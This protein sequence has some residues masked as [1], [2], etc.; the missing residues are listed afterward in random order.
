MAVLVV[1]VV[2]IILGIFSFGVGCS[3]QGPD[4]ACL[5]GKIIFF[6][7]VAG[8]GGMSISFIVDH[9]KKGASKTFKVLFFLF[10][11]IGYGISIFISNL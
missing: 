5:L 3:A 4:A 2:G 6:A 1:G 10:G 8:V 7:V 11:I 9:F